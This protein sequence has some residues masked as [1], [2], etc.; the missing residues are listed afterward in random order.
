MKCVARPLQSLVGKSRQFTPS[1]RVPGQKRYR[2]SVIRK[3]SYVQKHVLMSRNTSSTRSAAEK[4]R[5]STGERSLEMRI[6]GQD[7]VST[8]TQKSRC[9]ES[10][11]SPH[12]TRI[13]RGVWRCEESGKK[14]RPGMPNGITGPSSPLGKQHMLFTSHQ[15]LASG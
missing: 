14:N 11:N 8:E 7:S 6:S 9:A 12:S 5:Q 13:W 2:I 4:V 3:Q 10:L 1:Y 15:P